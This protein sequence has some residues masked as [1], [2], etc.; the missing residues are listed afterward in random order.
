[1]FAWEL[2]FYHPQAM[3]DIPA[4]MSQPT[5]D[6]LSAVFAVSRFSV[7]ICVNLLD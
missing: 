4:L 7:N 6:N 5:R 3:L 1:M 2:Y